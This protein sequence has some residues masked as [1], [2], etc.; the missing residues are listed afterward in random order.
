MDF[1]KLWRIYIDCMDGVLATQEKILFEILTADRTK[2]VPDTDA[3]P[4]SR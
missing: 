2:L 3:T 4:G 1:E